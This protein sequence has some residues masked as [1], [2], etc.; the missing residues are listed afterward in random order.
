MRVTLLKSIIE[1]NKLKV[2]MRKGREPVPFMRGAVVDM[3]DES[4]RKYIESGDAEEYVE[5]IKAEA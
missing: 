2:S 3:S 1:D 4:A 5:P